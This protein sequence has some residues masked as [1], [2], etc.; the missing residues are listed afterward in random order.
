MTGRLI[1]VGLVAS[2]AVLVVADRRAT[3]RTEAK[4]ARIAGELTKRP[5][6]VECQGRIAEFIDITGESGSVQFDVEGRPSGTTHLTRRVCSALADYSEARRRPDFS[7]V[8]AG[9]RCARRVFWTVEAVHTL[10]HESWHLAGVVDE[11]A[12]ECYALQS[13]ALVA[14]RLGSP[15]DEAQAV[16][17]YALAHLYP[18]LPDEYRSSTCVDG[19]PLDLRPGDPVWP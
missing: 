18:S 14:A 8:A 6:R 1:L 11:A 4:L 19:G 2:A 15:P 5:V 10:A 17:R 3:A 16:A 7:C 13:T 9:V 12:T